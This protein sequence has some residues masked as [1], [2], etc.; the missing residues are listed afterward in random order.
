MSL[1]QGIEIML[2]QIEEN[3][4]IVDHIPKYKSHCFQ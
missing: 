2:R 1:E 4:E 3:H